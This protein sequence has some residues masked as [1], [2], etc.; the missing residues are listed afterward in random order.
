MNNSQNGFTLIEIILSISILATIGV[1]TINILST[2]ID[3]REKVTAQNTAQHSI[4]MAMER[5]YSDIQSAYITNPN[6]SNSL[7]TNIRPI[8]PQFS[9]KNENL[10]MSVKNYKS[11]IEN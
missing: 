9:F 6:D 7:N 4:N 10:I 3:T 5:I 1:L 11:L 2:Q 8:I